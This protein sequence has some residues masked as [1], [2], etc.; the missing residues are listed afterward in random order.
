MTKVSCLVSR[1]VSNPNLE[2]IIISQNFSSLSRLVRVTGWC[3]RFIDNCRRADEKKE[4]ELEAE[5]YAHVEGLWIRSVQNEM[6]LDGGYEKRTQSLGVYE[7]ESGILRCRGRIGKAKIEFG[8][9]FPILIPT[10]HHVTELIIREAHEKVY[11]NGVKETLAEVRARYWIVKGRQNVKKIVSRCYLC[12]ILEC[13]GYPSPI[14]CDLPDFRVDGGRA[15]QTAGVDFCGPV[16]IKQMYQKDDQMNKA[17]IAI[18]TCATSRMIHLELTPDLTTSAYLRSQR[19]FT[20]RRGFPKMIVSDNGKTFRGSELRRY[21]AK[22]GIKWRFNLPRAPWWGG[23]FERMVRSTKRCLKK[24]VGH[25]RLT[26]EELLTILVEIE[27]V[28]NNRPLTYVDENDLDQVLTPSHLFCGRRTLDLATDSNTDPV[29]IGRNDG[30][31]R[32]RLVHSIIEHFWRRWSKEYLV[33]LRESHKMR[34]KQKKLKIDEG[35]VV[36]IHEDHVKR[37]K[38]RLGRIKEVTSGGD[39]IIRGAVLKTCREGK[40]GQIKRPL[41]KLYPLELKLES[42][43]SRAD[44]AA[45]IGEKNDADNYEDDQNLGNDDVHESGQNSEFLGPL[46]VATGGGTIQTHSDNIEKLLSRETNLKSRRAAAIDGQLRRR[47]NDM[48]NT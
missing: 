6:R 35:D 3:K 5:E 37:N 29:E 18:T 4:G 36:L 12:R 9:R 45:N 40:E 31:K 7:D 47:I 21:N 1:E 20:A 16:Y 32:M 22:Q 13:L 23:M 39:G 25:K 42:V 27:A 26:Y 14:S 10:S 17:Y 11:H 34:T 15:F 33:D 41:Q 24:V 46:G 43:G 44:A 2:K 28:I 38:W 19:R 8:T 48:K 30:V